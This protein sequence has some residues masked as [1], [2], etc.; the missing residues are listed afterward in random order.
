[1]ILCL[2]S[3]AIPSAVAASVDVYPGDDVAALTASLTPGSE[4]VFHEGTYTLASALRWTGE[5]TADAPIVLRAADGERPV[6]ELPPG[7]ADEIARIDASSF[8][9]LRGLTLQGGAGYEDDGFWGL[10]IV[11]SADIT[12]ADCEI[13]YTDY[14]GIY[15]GYD[16]S[17][18]AITGNHIH[19]VR[20]H[21]GVY[22]G[23]GDAA[24]WTL[25]S[26]FTGNWIHDVGD[27]DDYALAIAPGGAG[28]LV[29]DNV[30]YGVT[31]SGLY[32]GHTNLGAQ[33][34]VEGNVIWQATGGGVYALGPSVVRNNLV[35][36]VEGEGVRSY[37]DGW[38]ALA[39]VVI[40]HNTVVATGSW[41]AELDDWAGRAGMVFANN[42]LINPT[43]YALE[44]DEEGDIDAAA[45][46]SGNVASGLVLLYEAA[47]TQGVAPGGGFEDLSDAEA[48]DFY[49]APN[50]A[51]VDG[52]DAAGQ[53]WVPAVDFN[54]LPREGD[55]PDVG[56]YEFGGEGNPGWQIREGFKEPAEPR[57]AGEAVTGGCC[58][59]SEDT[60]AGVFFWLPALSLI[61]RRRRG[62]DR[63]RVV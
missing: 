34:T 9:E 14:A 61:I 4:V 39:D 58:G 40:T 32:V 46:L 56:A 22:A 33:N 50:S 6:I 36:N 12:V 60:A 11:D 3:P 42:A 31:G 7:I 51:L 53:A 19:Q 63:R 45:Y 27:G 2:L 26:A 13:A 57:A 18:V 8:L 28:N 52:G 10:Q 37:D 48:W 25:D 49:P 30:I 20:Y 44:A 41:A 23:C 5:G 35:F 29:A 15:L 54:G 59:R 62:R 17:R 43:G 24:C 1:M 38:D 16:N 47:N 55:A 21:S